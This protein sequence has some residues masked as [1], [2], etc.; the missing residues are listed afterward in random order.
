MKIFLKIVKHFLVEE[1]TAIHDRSVKEDAKLLNKAATFFGVGRD[2]GLAKSKRNLADDLV[3]RIKLFK[4]LDTDRRTL[5]ALKKL[6]QSYKITGAQE[7]KKKGYKNEGNFGPSLLNVINLLQGLYD[8]L[9]ERGLLDIEA[10]D[11]PFNKF[12]YFAA[13]YL[14]LK[15]MGTNNS[16]I[17]QKLWSHPKISN[18]SQLTSDKEDYVELML[19]KCSAAL[20]ALDTRLDEYQLNRKQC[21]LD[22]IATLL[23]G[24]INL[25]KSYGYKGEFPV[26][27]SLVSTF[28]FRLPSI[29]PATGLLKEC[30]EAAVREINGQNRKKEKIKVKTNNASTVITEKEN[31]YESEEE[32]ISG[33]ED[34]SSTLSLYKTQEKKKTVDR[35]KERD[36]PEVEDENAGESNSSK[37]II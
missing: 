31:K 16:S 25:C 4:E 14:C 6:I 11:D 28:V 19:K 13:L 22:C 10:N 12:Q 20:N 29:N 33:S 36:E 37:C 5:K 15:Y 32:K 3:S 17:L 9:D 30:M 21:V 35:K 27:V 1:I 26:S 34:D 7:S 18:S 24:N 2:P 8:T 23:T